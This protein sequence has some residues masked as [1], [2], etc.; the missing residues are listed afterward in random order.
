MS[1]QE[2]QINNL[3]NSMNHDDSNLVNSILNDINSSNM[4][5]QQMPQQRQQMN[6]QASMQQ[7]PSPQQPSPQQPSPEQIKMMQQQQMAMRQQQ[8]MQQ[9]Q[10]AQQQMEKN[11]KKMNIINND[12]INDDFITK[13]KND[14]KN[15]LLVI[16]LTFI[17]NLKQSDQIFSSIPFCF[18]DQGINIQGLLLKSLLIGAL[19]Y[20]I[21]SQLF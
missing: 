19:Y 14:S 3:S 12:P 10:M 4:N 15:I 21:K 17:F 13:I 11:D 8:I 2:T 9:Q 1:S 20:L 5:R 16:I 18:D 6:E 7:G